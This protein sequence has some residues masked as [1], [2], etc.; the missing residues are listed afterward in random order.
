M[1]WF[2]FYT[3]FEIVMDGNWCGELCC[4]GYQRCS[5]FIL[6]CA[7]QK[8]KK[9]L[10]VYNVIN[11][12]WN[13]GIFREFYSFAVYIRK[14]ILVAENTISKLNFNVKNVYSP[15]SPNTSLTRVNVNGIYRWH[16][17]SVNFAFIFVIHD[18]RKRLWPHSLF[19]T[20]PINIAYFRWQINRQLEYGEKKQE[21]S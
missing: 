12:Y 9:N 14:I 7:Q 21:V 11:D 13:F 10:L 18:C 19:N 8:K 2:A 1:D 6:T 20:R 16:M 17:S 3:T 15:N 5:Q 4:W